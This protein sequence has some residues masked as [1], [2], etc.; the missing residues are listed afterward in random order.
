MIQLKN[1]RNRMMMSPSI[2]S[3]PSSYSYWPSF[4]TITKNFSWASQLSEDASSHEIAENSTESNKHYAFPH[5]PNPTQEIWTKRKW[6]I[7]RRKELFP[8]STMNFTNGYKWIMVIFVQTSQK[9]F[10]ARGTTIRLQE[11]TWQIML[12]MWSRM[13]Q[14]YEVNENIVFRDNQSSMRRYKSAQLN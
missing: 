12:K 11:S 3:I 6:C 8:Q 13:A 14:G 2:P 5:S 9:Q 10:V 4:Q 7:F 1:C